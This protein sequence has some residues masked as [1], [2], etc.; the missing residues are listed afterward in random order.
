MLRRLIALAVLGSCAYCA[1]GDAKSHIEVR[2]E[3]AGMETIESAKVTFRV[4][5]SA[6]RNLTIRS[7]SLVS[8]SDS[9]AVSI[10]ASEFPASFEPDGVACP[11]P[12]EVTTIQEGPGRWVSLG[13]TYETVGTIDL[14]ERFANLGKIIG[15]CDLVV[16]WSYKPNLGVGVDVSRISGSLLISALRRLNEPSVA[17]AEIR[18]FDVKK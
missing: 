14:N 1:A 12:Q 4:T 6:D 11:S 15:R 2:M 13:R 3:G 18:F 5:F 9:S 8:D 10:T 17:N 16:F 7:E